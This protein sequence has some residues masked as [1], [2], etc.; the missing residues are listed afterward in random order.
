MHRFRIISQ[1][2]ATPSESLTLSECGRVLATGTVVAQFTM[3]KN[4]L[5][6]L[7][8]NQNLVTIPANTIEILP[9]N[10]LYDSGVTIELSAISGISAIAATTVFP[11]AER[12][13]VNDNGFIQF[14]LNSG[15]FTLSFSEPVNVATISLPDGL[16][17]QHF[18]DVDQPSDVFNMM[19]LDCPSATCFNGVNIKFLLTHSELNRIKLNQR[20]CSAAGNCWLT[21]NETFIQDMGTNFIEPVPDG[22][23][24][25]IRYAL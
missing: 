20:V 21:I 10:M 1:A 5:N 22:L 12:P 15:Q 23:H 17:F 19:E 6:N 3:S 11:D 4:D 2:S 25:D 18:S 8:L 9:G 7:K 14:D 13:I 16:Y 24:S